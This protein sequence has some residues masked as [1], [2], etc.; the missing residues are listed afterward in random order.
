MGND[1]HITLWGVITGSCYNHY[2][3]L[4]MGTTKSQITSLTNVFSTIYSGADQRKHQNS[5][6][7]AFVKAIHEFT[8]QRASNAEK[9]SIWG[10]HDAKST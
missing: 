5:A 2:S 10:R 3:D 9:V 8:A 1:V 4:I 7:L 6:S